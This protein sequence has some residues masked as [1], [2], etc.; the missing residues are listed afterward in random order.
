MNVIRIICGSIRT[1]FLKKR[2]FI[3]NPFHCFRKNTNF[4]SMYYRVFT[5]TQVTTNETT[6]SLF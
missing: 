5:Q 6:I 2:V 4:I 1:F 3:P